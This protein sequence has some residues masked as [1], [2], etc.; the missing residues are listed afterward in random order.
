MR[1]VLLTV[2]ALLA[3]SISAR[4]AGNTKL[5]IVDEVENLKD[6]DELK[7][8]EKSKEVLEKAENPETTSENETPQEKPSKSKAKKPLQ[9]NYLFHCPQLTDLITLIKSTSSRMKFRPSSTSTSKLTISFR[10]W[11][12]LLTSR[13]GK[14]TRF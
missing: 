4:P 1:L 5:K 2:G 6:G 3:V 12:K 11:S 14:K 13:E 8:E 7:I 10:L 9:S